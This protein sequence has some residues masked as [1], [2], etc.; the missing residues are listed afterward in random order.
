VDLKKHLVRRVGARRKQ[1]LFFAF[2]SFLEELF[3][4]K[5]RGKMGASGGAAE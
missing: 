2:N 5:V 3:V 1:L 4:K